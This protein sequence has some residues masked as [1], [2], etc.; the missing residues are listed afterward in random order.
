MRLPIYFIPTQ[1]SM[2]FLKILITI[3]EYVDIV[4]GDD[5]EGVTPLPI[6]NRAVKPLYADGT[7]SARAR[8]SRKSPELYF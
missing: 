1:A 5:S 8:E 7:R 3:F 6:P 4:L 2:D